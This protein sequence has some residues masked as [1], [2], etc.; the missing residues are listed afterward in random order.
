M[1]LSTKFREEILEELEQ[2]REIN[3]LSLNERMKAEANEA[4]KK[5]KETEEREQLKRERQKLITLISI[6]DY[7]IIS[8]FF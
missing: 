1:S 7:D 5:L 4:I 6:Q 8:K 3:L 2:G